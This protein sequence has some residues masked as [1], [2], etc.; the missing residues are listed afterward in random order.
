MSSH[1]GSEPRHVRDEPR[2][3]L[4][5]WC[6][7]ELFDQILQ[8]LTV[9][10][11]YP[12]LAQVCKLSNG[13]LWNYVDYQHMVDFMSIIN[14][15]RLDALHWTSD[16]VFRS[17]DLYNSDITLIPNYVE[18]LNNPRYF[19]LITPNKWGRKLEVASKINHPIC[20]NIIVDKYHQIGQSH[21]TQA[22]FKGITHGS[23][24]IATIDS[25]C[26]NK[27]WNLYLPSMETLGRNL[28]NSEDEMEW[29]DYIDMSTTVMKLLYEILW[30][31]G[32]TLILEYLFDRGLGE[33]FKFQEDI[34][35][36]CRNLFM[37]E[38]NSSLSSLEWLHDYYLTRVSKNL[39]DVIDTVDFHRLIEYDS[40][41][42]LLWYYEGFKL[43][44]KEIPIYE[45]QMTAPHPQGMI[46]LFDYACIAGTLEMIQL[47]HTMGQSS[48]TY[49]KLD[50]TENGIH[51]FS[52]SLKSKYMKIVKYIYQLVNSAH[53]KVQL[54]NPILNDLNNIFYKTITGTSSK[55]VP[56]D[57]EDLK[58]F[59]YQFLEWTMKELEYPMNI[60]SAFQTILFSE[61]QLST[62][63]DLVRIH[64][65]Y[66]EL[67]SNS[68]ERLEYNIQVNDLILKCVKTSSFSNLKWL[69]EMSMEEGFKIS[70]NEVFLCAVK[71]NEI[72]IVKW[73][74]GTYPIDIHIDNEYVWRWCV[75]HHA[76]WM[77]KT[78]VEIS[79]SHSYQPI[80]IH[81]SND[82]AF[83]TYCGNFKYHHM[84]KWL[85]DLSLYPPFTPINVAKLKDQ[86]M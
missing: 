27:G 20:K 83:R 40:Q 44:N 80:N 37:F 53:L 85:Y 8:Y 25:E 48:S 10:T 81:I 63:I 17:S 73:L 7:D 31:S 58:G 24:A 4:D 2:S 47:L 3:I 21:I 28:I 49:P 54:I 43:V 59:I 1:R 75:H 76:E 82:Y 15:D 57:N 29:E 50:L 5:V 68:P 12:V 35:S 45:L 70:L 19:D 86:I 69:L 67:Y 16:E 39:F 11:D 64:K 84:A 52:L 33:T 30:K 9:T 65:M 46:I 61:H 60:S 14:N 32:N 55:Y 26:R 79:L 71:Q 62:L 36:T 72:E 56:I 51:I 34:K 41:Q 74:C 78:L 77:I 22:F 18:Y 13:K 42:N 6:I 38:T 23:Y 66:E